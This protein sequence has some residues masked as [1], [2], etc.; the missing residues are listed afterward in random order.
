MQY[1]YLTDGLQDHQIDPAF[2][3]RGNL[4]T[5]ALTSLLERS[6]AQRLN[7]NTQRTYRSRDPG[8]KTLGRTVGNACTLQVDFV[9]VAS[10][11]MP[12]QA[13]GIGA[14]RVG[15][16]D[17]GPGLQILVVNLANQVRLRQI[18]FVI[19]TVDEDPLAI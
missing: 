14:E 7:A 9:Y 6:L 13:K 1:L 5:K 2:H 11:T 4:L 17:L 18:K 3:R 16:N 8:V 15:L 19:A 12:S 10:Q